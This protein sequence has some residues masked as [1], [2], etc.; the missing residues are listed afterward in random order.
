MLIKEL[1]V[2]NPTA[3]AVPSKLKETSRPQPKAEAPQPKEADMQSD[4]DDSACRPTINITLAYEPADIRHL[5]DTTYEAYIVNDSDYYLYLTYMTRADSADGWTVRFADIVEPDMQV[6]VQNIDPRADLA[7]MDRVA[8]Q[9]IAFKRGRSFRLKNPA[10]V[11]FALDTTKFFKLH[12]F[13]ASTYFDTPVISLAVVTDD[14]PYR[15][16]AIDSSRLED[17]MRR[18]TPKPKPIDRRSE[19]QRQ[20]KSAQRD[21][22]IVVDLHIHELLDN[23][24]GLSNA[25]ML[26][27][28]LKEFHRVM[29]ENASRHGQKIVFIHG[30]GEGVLRNALLKELRRHYPKATAQDASFREYGFGATQVTI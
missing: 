30:K 13:K 8:V 21:E 18:Q 9:Y 25:D 16:L 6:P 22:P 28:Q 14:V 20:S 15:T 3:K 4:T 19:P 2:V 7:E 24:T 10:L 27:T 23:L 26:Q 17:A 5:T 11:E 1:V 29:H 12:C